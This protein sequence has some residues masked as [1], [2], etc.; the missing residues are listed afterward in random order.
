MEIHP[1]GQPCPTPGSPA[2][3]ALRAPPR[4]RLA[5]LR[6]Q[7]MLRSRPLS[8]I[9]NQ[10]QA[11]SEVKYYALSGTHAVMLT[12]KGV[13]MRLPAAGSAGRLHTLHLTPVGLNPKAELTPVDPLAGKANYFKGRD[14]EQWRTNLPTYGAVLYREAYPGIDLKVYGTGRQLEYDVIVRPG[15][16]PSRVRFRAAGVQR[17]TVNDQ[18]DLVLSLPGGGSITQ[19]KPVVY[20]EIDGRRVPREGRFQVAAGKPGTYGFALGPYDPRYPLVIDPL[21]AVYSVTLG[22]TIAP[23]ERAKGWPWTRAATPMSRATPT[24]PTSPSP[25][26]PTRPPCRGYEDAFVTKLGPDGA[27]L[28]STFLGGGS[29]DEGRGIALDPDGNVYVVGTTESGNFPATVGAFDVTLNG[30]TDIFVAKLNNSL[31]ALAYATYLGGSGSEFGETA[32]ALN[33][34]REA[35]VTGYTASTDFPTTP[36]AYQTS[37]AGTGDAFVTRLNA[38]GLGAGLFHLSG[39]NGL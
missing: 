8:F 13:V 15:A 35:F 25:P 9:P 28:A 4:R 23:L 7:E 37:Q 16:D 31:S 18:G 24:P 22:G 29:Y 17:L 39:W 32:I 14:P 10:G 21:V 30:S 26:A 6:A 12:P 3:T 11:P 5:L 2:A 36:G 33:Q 34:S 20:Q 1:D 27:V 38:C 19:K